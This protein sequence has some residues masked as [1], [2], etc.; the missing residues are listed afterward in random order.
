MKK[1]YFALAIILHVFVKAQNVGINATGNAP[2]ASSMLDVS[3]TDKGLLIPRVFLSSTTDNTTVPTPTTS[4]LVYNTNA[5]IINGNGEGYYY[6]SGDPATPNWIKLYSSNGKTW[7]TIGNAGTSASAN[8]LGTTD[9]VDLVLRTNNTEK[10]RVTSSGS[11][12]IGTSAPGQLLE[13]NGGNILAWRYAAN[14]NIIQRRSNGAAGAESNL[15]LNDI[16]G[17]NNFQA[18][19]SSGSWPNVARIGAEADAAHTSSSMA[20]RLIFSTTPSGST[21]MT[22]RMR[23]DN[24]G[25]VGIGNTA[26]SY[27]LDITPNLT[28]GTGIRVI[29]N[30]TN[31]GVQLVTVGDDS[32]LTDLDV[33]N[34]LGI[35]GQQNS[36]VGSIQLGSGGGYLYGA[37]SNIGV[38]TTAPAS[39]LEVNAGSIR[40]SGSTNTN[41]ET[42]GMLVYNNTTGLGLGT[43][44]KIE[45][46]FNVT[47]SGTANSAVFFD[48]P[49]IQIRIRDGGSTGYL[50]ASPKS[51]STGTWSVFYVEQN[52]AN[53]FALTTAGTFYD[54]S[55]DF[56]NA[57]DGTIVTLSRQGVA[58]PLSF[59]KIFALHPSS[60][61]GGSPDHW[62]VVVEAYYF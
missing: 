15:A 37:N 34:T 54:I 62:I 55:A 4:L 8:F 3:A 39:K 61:A 6:N 35:Y 28:T 42:G 17:Y 58:N 13:V 60:S 51:G 25:N 30:S 31:A 16:I 26:P 21:T 52:I 5:S 32:Y 41:A 43:C 18:F 14:P 50:N 10:M 19:Q 45:R 44:K 27:K 56:N 48:D 36:A 2:D 53:G 46:S 40:I 59:Y 9:A 49:Y 57:N 22:E 12:G 29:D 7:E 1:I 24:N 47:T 23:I 33:V 20:T 38:G 11:V